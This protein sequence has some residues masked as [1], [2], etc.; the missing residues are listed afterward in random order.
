MQCS[1]HSLLP[2]LGRF[3]G[4]RICYLLQYSC[5]SLVAQV[6]KNLPAIRQTWV[7]SLGWEDP[8]RRERLPTPVFWPGEF[9]GLYICIVHG[10]ARSQDW[11][12]FTISNYFICKLT[13]SS[14]QRYSCWMDT[15]TAWIHTQTESKRV[16]KVT[17]CKW[18][19]KECQ[20]SY[21]RQSRFLQQRLSQET[22][23]DIT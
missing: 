15:S 3:P 20:D 8:Q 11:V 22:K 16:E 12:T 1:D 17:L 4:E 2:G 18:K 10:V 23:K 9:H 6:V 5:S 19:W 13:E 14:N 21:I 7:W